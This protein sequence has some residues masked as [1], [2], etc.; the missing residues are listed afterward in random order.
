MEEE[1]KE[2]QRMINTLRSSIKNKKQ[3][4]KTYEG[5]LK[6]PNIRNAEGQIAQKCELCFKLFANQEYLIT[7]YKKRHFE[8]YSKEI[9]PNEDSMLKNELGE[10]VQEMTQHAN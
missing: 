7:H 3:T 10:Y 2:N 4:L 8:Y 1:V 6:Q 5:I 9:R